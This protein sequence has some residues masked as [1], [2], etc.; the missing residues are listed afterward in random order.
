MWQDYALSIIFSIFCFTLIP[1]L[2]APEKPP[3]KSSIPTG[4][5]LISAA[6]VYATLHLWF[7]TITQIIVGCQWLIL[8]YQKW[9]QSKN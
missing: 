8:A 2:L 3:L 4:L 1:M 7:S 9:H 6:A 5:L